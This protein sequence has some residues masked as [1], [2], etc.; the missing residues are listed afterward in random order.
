MNVITALGLTSNLYTHSGL[1]VIP[2]LFMFLLLVVVFELYSLT[3]TY[4]SIKLVWA[5]NSPAISIPGSEV[6]LLLF[7]CS[8]CFV[9]VIVV[10]VIVLFLFTY[11][12]TCCCLFLFLFFLFVFLFIIN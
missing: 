3:T 4:G 10:I 2:V 12:L 6:L 8:Y 1:F 5:Y 7:C 11:L 9:V